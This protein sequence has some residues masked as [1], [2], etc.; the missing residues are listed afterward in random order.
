M[1][2]HIGAGEMAQGVKVSA[3]ESGGLSLMSRI[4]TVGGKNLLCTLSWDLHI[5]S[6]A[7]V[8]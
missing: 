8:Y 3:A 1:K 6:V 5:Y 4:D 7:W 2:T